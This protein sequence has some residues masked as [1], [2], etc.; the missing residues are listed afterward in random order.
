MLMTRATLALSLALAAG[1]LEGGTGRPVAA[2]QTTGAQG[3][4]QAPA[5]DPAAPTNPQSGDTPQQPTFRA[6]INYVRVDVIVSDDKGQPV[7]DLKV[8]DFEVLEDGKPQAIDQFR[9]VRVDGN[10]APGAPPPREHR[11]LNDE[12]VEISKHDI[13]AGGI[14]A[15]RLADE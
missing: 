9:L 6:D 1:L 11:H 13:R 3:G 8:T 12:E 5:T 2:Q 10:P 15:A 14:G 4:A 7:T